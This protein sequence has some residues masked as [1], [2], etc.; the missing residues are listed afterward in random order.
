PDGRVRSAEDARELLDLHAGE[1]AQLDDAGLERIE[2]R[3]MNQGLVQSQQPFGSDRR[4]RLHV[5]QGQAIP[6][7]SALLAG[8]LARMI[9]EHAT[10]RGRG[11]GEELRA[12]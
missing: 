11:G 1:E 8:A 5:F 10:D 3:E 9:D 4:F 12:V 7:A 2:T 6:I